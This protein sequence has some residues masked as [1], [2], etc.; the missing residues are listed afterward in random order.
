MACLEAV[1]LDQYRD[2][3]PTV[4]FKRK[5]LAAVQDAIRLHP[6]S[7]ASNYIDAFILNKD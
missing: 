2:D 4:V 7:L 3:M 6:K 1:L 5:P